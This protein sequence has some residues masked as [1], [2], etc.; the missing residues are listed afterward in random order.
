M[1]NRAPCTRLLLLL[2]LLAVAGRRL[3]DLRIRESRL[4]VCL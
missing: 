3:A 1:T 2:L 4:P